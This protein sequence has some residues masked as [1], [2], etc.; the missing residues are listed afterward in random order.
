MN[1]II[2]DA[3]AWAC[4]FSAACADHE[5]FRPVLEAIET[6]RRIVAWGGTGYITELKRC[7]RY[8]GI[9]VELERQR[10]ARRFA[11]AHVDVV[12]VEVQAKEE[13]PDFDDAH[14]IALQIV[15]G[16][17][18]ICSGDRRANRFFKKRELYPKRHRRPRI[19]SSRR[20]S[21][22]MG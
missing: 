9:H 3:C 14:I 12:E 17:V 13:D 5:N 1:L 16:A 6:R 10:K 22:L 15:S 20:N 21:E 11:D 19:Y 7:R 4:V 2:I 18:V 8:L